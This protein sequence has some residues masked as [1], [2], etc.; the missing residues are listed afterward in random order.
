M[1]VSPSLAWGFA[2]VT[3]AA[4]AVLPLAC[5]GGLPPSTAPGDSGTPAGSLVAACPV[6]V[7]DSG[8][9]CQQPGELDCEYGNDWNPQCNEVAQCWR[10]GPL[11]ATWQVQLPYQ[12]TDFACP[13]A[14]SLSPSCPSSVPETQ[15]GV[16]SACTSAGVF[17]PYG[18]VMCG[19]IQQDSS[20]A[21]ASYSFSW[22][23]SSPGPGCP[24]ARPRIGSACSTSQ[25][26][27]F[28]EYAVCGVGGATSCENGVWAEGILLNY[29]D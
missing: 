21:D 13:S 14:T 5:G 7:P 19:C 8:S 23:C 11:N 27:A 12:G 15:T 4:T 20:G 24:A 10:G 25:Q 18:P 29:C 6:L 22:V 26:G 16:G 2:L 28:C 1:P 17:C 3:W 9:P